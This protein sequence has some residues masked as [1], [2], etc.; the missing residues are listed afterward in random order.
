MIF[1]DVNVLINAFR[2]ESPFHSPARQLAETL[3][4]VDI[5]VV[6]GGT[7]HNEPKDLWHAE[8]G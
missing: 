2:S 4:M 3:G 8:H 6:G 7:H 5:R 1:C